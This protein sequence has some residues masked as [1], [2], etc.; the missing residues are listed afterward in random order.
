MGRMA[1]SPPDEKWSLSDLVAL[2]A[3]QSLPSGYVP[4][5]AW[6]MR[7]AAVASVVNEL[8]RGRR[9]TVVELG[10]GASTI[11]LGH[12]LA[13]LGGRLVS[14]EHD[15]GY[16]GHVRRLLEREGLADVVALEVVPLAPWTPPEP[17]PATD[18]A[19]DP[20]FG[21]AATDA[22][23][24]AAATDAA[25]GAGEAPGEAAWRAPETW[26]DAARLLEVCP[27]E[28]DALVVDGPPA[29]MHPD[30]LVREPAL[31]VLR[32]RL[33]ADWSL[34]L[35]DADR[36]AERETLRRW[37]AA[38]GVEVTPVDRIGLGA[39]RAGGGFVPTL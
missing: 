38:L 35:D 30:T 2:S 8:L 15:A 13:D 5:T 28:I 39:A 16:A 33:A 37:S 29:G 21:A 4:W 25:F 19:T 10:S 12:T 18:P 26:Y 3:L 9:R 23:F 27:P 7:P 32:P 20:A 14:V 11:F 34:F 36:P 24:G 22:A 17:P 31:G 1:Q 6:S